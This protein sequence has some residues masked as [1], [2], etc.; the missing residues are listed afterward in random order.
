MSLWT[1]GPHKLALVGK[2]HL[3]NAPLPLQSTRTKRCIFYKSTSE[4]CFE[5]LT[6][7]VCD[8]TFVSFPLPC[9]L[10]SFCFYRVFVVFVMQIVQVRDSDRLVAQENLVQNQFTGRFVEGE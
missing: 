2:K 4:N 5:I 10:W 1:Q 9:I 7:L 8:I 3:P 6:L